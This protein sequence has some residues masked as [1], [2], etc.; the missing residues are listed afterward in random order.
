MDVHIFTLKINGFIKKDAPMLFASLFWTSINQVVKSS[1]YITRC[2]IITTRVKG[3]N[4]TIVTVANSNG[5][6]HIKEMVDR[7]FG[8]R[9][10]FFKSEKNLGNCTIILGHYQRDY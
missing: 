2:D 6:I 4:N 9:Q 1:L 10:F 8:T 3:G 7:R 5:L